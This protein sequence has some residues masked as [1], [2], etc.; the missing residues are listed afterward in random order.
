MQ[1]FRVNEMIHNHSV[2]VIGPEGE[3][4]GIMP[5]KAALTKAKELFLDLIEIVPK[6]TP[7]VCKIM[8]FG[9]F[10]YEI[11]KKEKD[12]KKKQHIVVEKTI[13]L[14]PNIGENDLVRKVGEVV[15]FLEKGFKVILIVEM[16]G[17]ENSHP[18]LAYEQVNKIKADLIAKFGE[19]LPTKV[20]RA[21]NRISTILQRKV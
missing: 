11:T 19:L 3:Q 20:E 13:K 14:T 10:R 21:E 1:K 8:D 17:R 15:T 6:A 4:L 16:K 2:R 18:E 9:K 5:C 12:A 7:P